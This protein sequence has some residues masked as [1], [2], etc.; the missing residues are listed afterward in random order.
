MIDIIIPIYNA[1]DVV[2]ECINSVLKNTDL[3]KNRLILIDD[4]STDVR[5]FSL[6]EKYKEENLDKKIIVLKNEK[7][8]GFVGTVNKG[9]SYSES[10]VILLNSDTEVPYKWVERLNAC[11][12]SQSDIATVTALSNNATLASVPIGLQK[13]TIPENMTF[14]E[15][16]NMI[17][18]TSFREY[19]QIPTAHGFCMYIRRKV[20]DIVGYFD[21]KTFGKGYG[22]ENDFS[23]RCMDYGFKHLLC[24]D[25]LVYHKESQSFDKKKDE[26]IKYNMEKLK[27][28]YPAYVENTSQWCSRFPIQ[29]ICDNVFYN[30]QFYNRKNILF[31]IHD[32]S[33]IDKN[34]GG[35][36]LHCKDLIWNLRKYFNFHVLAPENG[37]FKLYS[38]FKD[39]ER[40]LYL[41]R[42]PNNGMRSLYDLDYKRMLVDI[43][44][45]LGISFVHVHHMIGHYFDIIDVCKEKNIKSVI[46]LHDFYCLCPTV[47]LIYKTEFC[48]PLKNKDCASCLKEKKGIINNIIPVWKS[49]WR[50]F[51]LKFD[52][53]LVPS[54]STKTIIESNLHDINCIILE[55]GVKLERKSAKRLDSKDVLNVAFVGVMTEHKGS[56]V[57]KYLIDNTSNKKIQYHL[58][59]DSLVDGL[60]HNKNN[61][62][63]HGRYTRDNLPELLGQNNIHLVC[64]LSIWPETY[65]YTLTETIASGIPVLSFDIGAVGERIK[66]YG[67]GWT[68]NETNEKCVLEKI[69]C[70]FDD[71]DDYNDKVDNINLYEIKSVEEM[72][73]SYVDIYGSVVLRENSPNSLQHLFWMDALYKQ[74]KVLD[75]NSIYFNS[76]RWKLMKN[77]KIPSIVSNFV[78]LIRR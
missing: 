35:T 12:Y 30:I 2:N 29:N 46:T 26:L 58:F 25:V 76:K 61:Y 63:Y 20:L 31:L 28:R 62:I 72:I 42:V 67:F 59:G 33:N 15:Y 65:S 51:L 1:Y 60:K 23:Y 14:E 3:T 7:N 52:K 40:V 73:K 45:G 24:D 71:I 37:R 10:D 70:I 77:L 48:L 50:E 68:L 34:V 54:Q 64:N 4:Q 8:L 55:H 53:V 44:D 74:F 66:K 49:N 13:N 38:Y 32:W 17:S 5:I 18:K 39:S 43:I 27:Q 47:N 36:T 11:A 41:N 19:P 21:E 22:E 16:A 6:L 57:L 56:N 9:M 69:S 75:E 78:R